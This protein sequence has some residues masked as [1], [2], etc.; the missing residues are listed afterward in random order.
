ML[1]RI[2]PFVVLLVACASEPAP[3]QARS[4]DSTEG[5]AAPADLPWTQ[6]FTEL[7]VLVASEVRIE[8][9]P[10]L[11]EHFVQNQDSENH[12]YRVRTVP[13]GL[14]Q[15]TAV[16]ELGSVFP[17]RCNLDSLT[18][19]AER[20]LT[21]LERPGEVPVRV[22]ARGDAYWKRTNSEN[23]RRGEELELIGHRPR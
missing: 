9:P 20:S 17:I 22:F 18:I 1:L 10:G 3:E 13:E 11:R 14:M 15:E 4:S 23:E 16:K 2:L 5:S 8:G 7:A 19:V 21:V 6:E 12:T